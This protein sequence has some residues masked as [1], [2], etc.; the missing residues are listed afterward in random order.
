MQVKPITYAMNC[1]KTN[2]VNSHHPI[3]HQIEKELIE[4]FDNML[5]E[6]GLIGYFLPMFNQRYSTHIQYIDA[7]GDIY[8]VEIKSSIME[9]LGKLLLLPIVDYRLMIKNPNEIDFNDL[10]ILP[11]SYPHL[12]RLKFY[13]YHKGLYNLYNLII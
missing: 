4:T 8:L 9:T 5:D 7:F 2:C 3:V 12:D 10:I 13:Y 6:M 1:G 11:Y